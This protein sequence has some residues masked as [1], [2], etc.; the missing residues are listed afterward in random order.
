MDK[1]V[2]KFV[3]EFMASHGK[4]ELS[5]GE[6][7]QVVGGELSGLYLNGKFV[8]KETVYNLFLNMT[9]KFGYMTAANV[10]CKATGFSENEIGKA[11][12]GSQ[13]DKENMYCLITQCFTT[14]DKIQN[15]GKTY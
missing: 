8:D 10:F 12:S 14:F 7:E 5:D 11:M 15:G 1:N 3:N 6:L 2:E 4:R 13:T 9:D